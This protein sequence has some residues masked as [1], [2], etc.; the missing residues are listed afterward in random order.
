LYLK[1]YDNGVGI[2][3]KDLLNPNSFGLLG[4]Y[5]QIKSLNGEF[6]IKGTKNKGTSLTVKLPL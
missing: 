2:K 6:N 5:E 1:I 3:K 4:I